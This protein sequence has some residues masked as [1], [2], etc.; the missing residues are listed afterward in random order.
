MP[1]VLKSYPKL[2]APSKSCDCHIHVYGPRDEYPPA[3]S[4]PFPPPL[5]LVEDYRYVMK[6]LAI[7]RVIVV[8]PLA[9]GTDNRCTVDAIQQLGLE[10]TRGV[11]VINESFSDKELTA[12]YGKGIRGIRFCM[13][14][15][16]T[17]AWE[18]L[19]KLAGKIHPFGWHIQLQMDG[20]QLTEQESILRQ[21]PCNIV[22]DHVG[23]YLGP[24]DIDHP[25][26]RSL[27]R[28]VDTGRC[29]VKLSSP[30]ES[31]IEGPPHYKDV[32]KLAKKLAKSAP[33]R[34]LWGSNWPHPTEKENRP[35]DAVL[36]DLLLDWVEDDTSRQKILVDN[37]AK[38]YGF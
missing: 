8:Q 34:M 31:S 37:P 33:E 38:F 12:L 11:A 30:Y 25:A 22:V 16:G 13:I 35:D 29:W 10:N 9:Y 2:I 27:L 24:V 23:K 3:P 6:L 32:G 14:P 7:E 20:M 1:I 5:A 36:L 26:F 21:L 4:S 18:D 15:G 17:L 19:P 28:L